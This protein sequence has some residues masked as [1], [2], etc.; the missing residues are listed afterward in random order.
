MTV[1]DGLGNAKAVRDD[2]AVETDKTNVLVGKV[3]LAVGQ[4]L[5]GT[6]VGDEVVA[7]LTS[8]AG[9]G[10]DVGLT[11]GDDDDLTTDAV[12]EEVTTGA[13]GADVEVGKVSDAVGEA[14][15]VTEVVEEVVASGA[16][17]TGTVGVVSQT[18]GDVGT[19]A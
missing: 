2:V 18:V 16:V 13:V 7:S 5:G 6:G 3:L 9:D 10:V 12:G 14:L 11:V 8:R 4:V 17:G 19:Y 15:G 1:G